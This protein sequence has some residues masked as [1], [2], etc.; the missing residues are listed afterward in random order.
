MKTCKVC[1]RPVRKTVLALV[2]VDGKLK[3]A[4]VC[5]ECERK[6]GVTIVVAPAGKRCSCGKAATKCGAC[7]TDAERKTVAEG[8]APA[9]KVIQGWIKASGLALPQLSEEARDSQRARIEALESVVELLTSG[10]A[11]A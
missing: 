4:R 5:Q 2:M 3:G 7:A 10:R 9:V 11:A 1:S 6:H 8:D